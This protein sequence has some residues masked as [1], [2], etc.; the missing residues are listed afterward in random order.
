LTVK[1][2]CGEDTETKELYIEVLDGPVADFYTEMR[3]V[4]KGAFVYFY[5]ES[6]NATSYLWDFGDGATSPEEHPSHPYTKAGV[7]TVKLTATN[8]C[9]DDT[10]TKE[11]Y[12]VVHGGPTADFSAT[13]RSGTAPLDVDFTDHSTTDLVITSWS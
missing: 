3:E 1:G 10:E 2:D 9:G 7:Y 12:I 4:C 11:E 5:N 8:G 13:P 6:Q